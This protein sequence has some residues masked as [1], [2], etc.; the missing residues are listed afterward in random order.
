MS[1]ARSLGCGG[2][3][4]RAERRRAKYSYLVA[5]E[6][7]CRLGRLLMPC[8]LRELSPSSQASQLYESQP[9]IHC[10]PLSPLSSSFFLPSCV[11]ISFKSLVRLSLAKLAF[12]GQL[13]THTFV[14]SQNRLSFRP[15]LQTD[16]PPFRAP[17]QPLVTR[18]LLCSLKPR[19]TKSFSPEKKQKRYGSQLS[20]TRLDDQF[21][22][23]RAEQL[24]IL[25]H[26]QHGLRRCEAS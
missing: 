8:P 12:T 2:R 6:A 17:C 23:P 10:L 14:V 4:V 20:P 18:Y 1:S 13:G 7:R 15:S 26:L 11:K 22:F 21:N 9:P 24:K 16:H 3:R 5:A 19:V 25:R